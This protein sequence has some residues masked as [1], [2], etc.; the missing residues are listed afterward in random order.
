[1]MNPGCKYCLARSGVAGLTALLL[2]V[3]VGMVHPPIIATRMASAMQVVE[4]VP[5]S[6]L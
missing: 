1:M 3:V 2:S 6:G 4:I 5:V